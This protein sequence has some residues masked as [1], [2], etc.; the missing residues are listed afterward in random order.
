MHVDH[1]AAVDL[2]LVELEPRQVAQTRIAG[3]E[4]VERQAYAERAQA[5]ERDHRALD[6]LDQQRLG[7]LE[8]EPVRR[9]P[10]LRQNGGDPLGD[11]GLAQLQRRQVDRDVEIGAPECRRLARQTQHLLAERADRAGLLGDRNERLGRHLAADRM[12]PAHQR[13]GADDLAIVEPDLGLERDADLVA[14]DRA[15]QVDLELVAVV[16]R[17]LEIGAIDAERRRRAG[18]RLMLREVGAFERIL[19]AVG[20]AADQRDA[21][22]DAELQAM[23]IDFERHRQRV[24][25]ALR[26]PDRGGLVGRAVDQH[27]ELVAAEFGRHAADA[28]R[29]ADAPRRLDQ[30]PVADQVAEQRADR[31]EA[32]DVERDE[33]GGRDAAADRGLEALAQAGAVGQAGQ[34]VVV[35]HVL[36]QRRGRRGWHSRDRAPARP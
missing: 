28:D 24:G 14:A 20:R 15:Q 27:G 13:L 35:R 36:D 31:L 29:L 33:G 10:S 2:E 34:V 9:Q 5:L 17:A 32:V 3:A 4:V 23:A 22:A 25:Q 11:V 16:Q 8:V 12:L 30:Q 7:D 26:D 1:E 18:R 6:V 21:G 19:A